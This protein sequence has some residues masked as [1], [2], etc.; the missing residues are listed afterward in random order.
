MA[1]SVLAD[2]I[3]EAL[4]KVDR[5]K[6]TIAEADRQVSKAKEEQVKL[7]QTVQSQ[8]ESL[9]AD[10]RRLEEELRVAEASLPQ[11]LR[12]AYIRVVKAKGEDAMAQ[13]EG[14]SCGGCHQQL[15][16]NIMSLLLGANV[17]FCRTCGRL[18]YLPEDRTPG[19]KSS[20]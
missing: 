16:P 18:L 7:Q 4:E 20:T 14:E 9:R 8:E 2:E 6:Q 11:E 10:V 15:T 3:L 19:R 17:V 1:N 13:V 12:D 5:F